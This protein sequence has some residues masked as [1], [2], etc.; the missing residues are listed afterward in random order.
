LNDGAVRQSN[1][2]RPLLNLILAAM[3]AFQNQSA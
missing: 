3:S 1:V 2:D